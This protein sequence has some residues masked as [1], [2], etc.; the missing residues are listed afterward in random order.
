VRF[1]VICNDPV[2]RQV[3]ES[4]AMALAVKC[5]NRMAQIEW[6]RE[7]GNETAYGR[8]VSSDGE[9]P[10]TATLER[11]IGLEIE[12]ADRALHMLRIVNHDRAEAAAAA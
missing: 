9:G 3:F 6:D 8:A 7:S 2:S 11:K 5:G 1:F 12:A 10:L 4:L